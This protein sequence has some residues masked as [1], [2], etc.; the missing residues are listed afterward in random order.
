[1]PPNP[2]FQVC[3]VVNDL[4]SSIERWRRSAAVGPFY[5]F[6]HP[7]IKDFR[8]R[9]VPGRMDMS[10]GITQAGPIQIELIEQHDA[11][12]SAYRDTYSPGQEGM[13]HVCG[14]VPNYDTEVAR[15]Q[16]LGVA[17]AHSGVSGEMR[18]CYVDTRATIGCM[19]EVLEECASTRAMFRVIAEASQN[20]DGTD[21]LRTL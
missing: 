14:F 18:F 7:L 21:P 2:F 5:V 1:M 4:D 19:T 16:N 11:R 8:Y 17:I 20:W 6:R 12:P 3:W 9:G 15:Y 13:H 10:V